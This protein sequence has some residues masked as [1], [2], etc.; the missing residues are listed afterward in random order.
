MLLAH[1]GYQAAE[2]RPS[3]IGV[4]RSSP[5]YAGLGSSTTFVRHIRVAARTMPGSARAA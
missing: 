3:S 4:P 5:T 2:G 1:E